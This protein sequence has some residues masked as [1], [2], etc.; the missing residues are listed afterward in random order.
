MMRFFVVACAVLGLSELAPVRAQFVVGSM[1][2]PGYGFG[3]GYSYR[4]GF[5]F[6]FGGPHVRVSGFGG[7]FVSRAVFYP[8][9]VPVAPLGPV[10][11][12]GPAY[13]NRWGVAPPIVIVTPPP[14]IVGGNF[15]APDPDAAANNVPPPRND[16]VVFPRGAKETDFIVISPKKGTTVPEVTRVAPPPLPPPPMGAFDPFK[17]VTKVAAEYPEADPKK[18]AARLVKLARTAFALG[19]Y[20]RA[21]EHFER[22]ITADPAD[23]RAYF[24]QAQARFATG[25]FAEAVARIRDGLARDAKWP[26]A[27]FDPAEM[28][29][30]RADRFTTHLA[31]LKKAVADNPGQAA[32]EFLLGYELWFSGEK[33]E[34]EKLFR[35]AEK[36][37][38]APGPISLFK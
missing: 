16:A 18:E 10:G 35:A 8:P 4:G 11:F 27:A 29:D 15:D 23:A 32:L 37:L 25:Q 14:I 33:A 1:P 17:P 22:A 28:Y 21:A 2:G 30:G 7:G 19:D 31:A 36:R 26:T 34:A 20:G 6:S 5:G 3:G 13:W 38:A 12:S 9:L 24:L